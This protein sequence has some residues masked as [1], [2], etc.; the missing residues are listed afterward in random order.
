MEIIADPTLV[1]QTSNLFVLCTNVNNYSYRVELSMN[2]HEEKGLCHAEAKTISTKKQYEHAHE[3]LVG[4]A[5]KPDLG[6]HCLQELSADD[7]TSQ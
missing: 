3:I 2:I 1:D 7:K 6:P 5:Y 4:I